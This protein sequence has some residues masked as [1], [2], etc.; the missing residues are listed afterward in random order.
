MQVR[1]RYLILCIV[2]FILPYSQF[3]PWVLA[4]GIDARL[5]VHKL[6][7]NRIGGFFGLDVIVSAFVLIPFILTEGR[8]LR[9]NHL[10]APVVGTLCVGVS[11]G[12]PLFLLM[13]EPDL[14]QATRP[15][16]S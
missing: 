15:G 1:V 3:V 8:R 4:H 13:R 10:W 9:M 14:R 11:F 5:F 16:V 6:F 12:F 2:G 7:S